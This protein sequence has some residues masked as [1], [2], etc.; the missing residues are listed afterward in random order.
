MRGGGYGKGTSFYI[1][2]KGIGRVFL[3]G[4][5]SG[6]GVQWKRIQ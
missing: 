2:G 6:M 1:K 3:V 5:N 4:K